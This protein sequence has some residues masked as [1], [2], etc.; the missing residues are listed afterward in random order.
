MKVGPQI[1]K[2]PIDTRLHTSVL[3]GLGIVRVPFRSISRIP[4][5]K[6]SRN[7]KNKRT[8]SREFNVKTHVKLSRLQHSGLEFIRY[9]KRGQAGFFFISP[10]LV[11]RSFLTLRIALF[12]LCG[13]SGQF[14]HFFR[15]LGYACISTRLRPIGNGSDIRYR[16]TT[17]N[18][19]V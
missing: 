7:L 16:T 15:F 19:T 12:Q 5:I 9:H 17:F 8:T 6:I 10:V 14:C 4:L 3:A 2:C 18:I 13:P 1:L 11:S